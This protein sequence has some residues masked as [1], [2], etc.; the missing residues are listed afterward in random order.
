MALHALFAARLHTPH[1]EISNGVVLLE[2]ES[3]REAGSRADTAIPDSARRSE[4]G[5]CTIAPGFID[6]H[7]H[8]GAGHDV[9]EAD[10]AALGAVARHLLRHGTTS[11]LPTTVSAPTAQ[12]EAALR[13]L[14]RTLSSRSYASEGP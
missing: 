13:G 8:G 2:D 9:M 4:L 14:G 11:F 5:D 1:A 12:L 7:I 10:G 6:V 3:I